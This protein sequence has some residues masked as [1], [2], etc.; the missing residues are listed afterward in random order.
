MGQL[1]HIRS[2]LVVEDEYL[3]AAQFFDALAERGVGSIDIVTSCAAAL[4]HVSANGADVVIVDVSL[5]DGRCDLLVT[6]LVKRSIPFV[7]SSGY[8]EIETLGLPPA[9][10]LPK[11]ATDEQVAS[12][13]FRSVLNASQANQNEAMAHEGSAL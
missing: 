9:I 5:P 6:E 12:A 2:A 3:I 1:S 8:R 13:V 4:E 10:L 7:Y 11:P